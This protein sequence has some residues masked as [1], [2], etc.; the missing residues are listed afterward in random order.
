MSNFPSRE[1]PC[2]AWSGISRTI[3]VIVFLPEAVVSKN[4]RICSVGERYNMSFKIVRTDSRLVRRI[5]MN[6]GFHEVHPNS[7]NFNLMW[8][9]SHL[10]PY[11]LHSLQEFQKVNHF[12]RYAEIPRCPVTGFCIINNTTNPFQTPQFRQCIFWLPLQHT[13][14]LDWCLSEA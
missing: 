12:P 11:L 14:S 3:P 1:H 6:H 4:R 9:G 7:N 5:L 2:I 10:K 8:T 13:F